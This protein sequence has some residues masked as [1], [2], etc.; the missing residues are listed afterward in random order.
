[1]SGPLCWKFCRSV[2]ITL[3][4]CVSNV[5]GSN[6]GR[7]TGFSEWGFSWLSQLLQKDTGIVTRIGRDCFLL[8]P[9]HFIIY[10][11]SYHSTL[12]SVFHNRFAIL[13]E[14]N[15][16]ISSSERTLTQHWSYIQ[17]FRSYG[18][19]NDKCLHLWNSVGSNTSDDF[20]WIVATADSLSFLASFAS[21]PCQ[22]WHYFAII[23][24]SYCLRAY[25]CKITQRLTPTLYADVH[26]I[27]GFCDT[28]SRAEVDGYRKCSPKRRN[29][30]R[31]VLSDI[32][33]RLWDTQPRTCGTTACACGRTHTGPGT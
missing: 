29:P 2:L 33:Q 8:N 9:F 3:H 23:L 14:V 5:L 17:P 24:K 26:Y 15:R 18:C 4:T 12:C 11:S 6:I 27:C 21:D 22:T 32:R 30:N 16:E 13:R 1:M 31:Q 20:I 7:D 28:N 25:F 19:T 10:Q